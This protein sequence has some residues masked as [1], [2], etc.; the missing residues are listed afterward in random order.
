MRVV[1]LYGMGGMGKTSICKALCNEFS[2]EF[3]GRVCHAEL[4]R[5]SKEELMREVLKRVTDASHELIN[6]WREDE[7]CSSYQQLKRR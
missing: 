6:G 4:G 1:G 7:V 2:S 3:H 5:G